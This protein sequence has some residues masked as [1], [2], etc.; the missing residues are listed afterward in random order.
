MCGITRPAAGHDQDDVERIGHPDDAQQ[1]GRGDDAGDR[2]QGDVEKLAPGAGAVDLG[3]LVE[4]ARNRLQA[5]Q[6]SD[7]EERETLPDQRE[8]DAGQ[9]RGGLGEP[10]MR[11]RDQTEAQKDVVEDAEIEIVDPGPHQAD[12]HAR[13]SPRDDDER[14]RQAAPPEAL[15]EQQ[16]RAK[17]EQKLQGHDA[18]DPDRGVRERNPEDLVGERGREV[19]Q[20]HEAEIVRIVEDVFVQAVPGRLQHRKQDD[21]RRHQQCRQQESIR[22]PS[23]K[24]RAARRQLVHGVVPVDRWLAPDQARRHAMRSGLSRGRSARRPS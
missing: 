18:S 23:A 7:G 4:L 11:R 5:R 13:Q 19:A 14:A 2:G 8:H 20:A 12:D 17:A 3:R 22:G 24:R 1:H 21:K 15:I 6:D 16:R 10:G 9:R